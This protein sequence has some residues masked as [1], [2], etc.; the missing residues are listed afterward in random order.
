MWNH[1]IHFHNYLLSQVPK[2][3][4]RVLDVG[5]GSGLLAWKIAKISDRVDAID[6]DEMILKEALN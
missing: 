6:S 3:N 4:N 1:N 5:C 2:K